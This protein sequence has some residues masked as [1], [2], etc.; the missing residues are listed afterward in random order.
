[1]HCCSLG[2]RVDRDIKSKES[3]IQFSPFSGAEWLCFTFSRALAATRG[4][5]REETLP[6]SN[7]VFIKA[8]R[9]PKV[10]VIAGRGAVL[11]A[12][13]ALEKACRSSSGAQSPGLGDG[14]GEGTVNPF[15]FFPDTW[16]C[17]ESQPCMH[18]WISRGHTAPL[19]CKVDTE[20]LERPPLPQ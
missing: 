13:P 11:Q 2:E 4:L 8:Q 19:S 6:L 16:C 15:Q 7:T 20:Q 9:P 10:Q 12:Q 14:G 17:V 3:S 5:G 1:M 18:W